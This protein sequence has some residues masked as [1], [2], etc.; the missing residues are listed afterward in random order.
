MF[1]SPLEPFPIDEIDPGDA[2][3]GE[4]WLV[5]LKWL[6][7]SCDENALPAGLAINRAG[8]LL[9]WRIPDHVSDYVSLGKFMQP[10]RIGPED[11]WHEAALLLWTYNAGL[12]LTPGVR[13]LWF[14]AAD[15][16]GR[17]LVLA[18][19]LECDYKRSGWMRPPREPQT[20][21]ENTIDRFAASTLS[22]RPRHGSVEQ[23]KSARSLNLAWTELVG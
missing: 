4:Q 14:L 23:P 20:L 1:P 19:K 22:R 9:R 2:P 10:V 13:I 11:A 15:A 5:S 8:E 12:N 18:A 16:H 17:R 6:L 21:V 7:R 3:G